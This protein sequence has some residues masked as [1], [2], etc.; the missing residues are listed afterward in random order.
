MCGI[1]G[2]LS[3][4]HQIDRSTLERMNNVARHRGPDDE[5]YALISRKSVNLFCGRDSRS[6]NFPLFPEGVFEDTFL[7]FGH[8]RL[9]ILDLSMKGHQPMCS[10]DG[11]ICV[12]FN[13]EIYNYIELRREL[14]SKGHTF[15]S[16]SD[17][18]VLIASYRE[19]G[20]D[21]VAHFNGMWGFAIWDEAR[22]KLFCSRDRLGAK[23]FYYYKD[24]ENFLFSSEMKQICQN[25]IVPRRMNESLLA[26]EI[27]WRIS[28][29]SDECWLQ[30][31]KVLQ[32]GDNLVL[33]IADTDGDRIEDCRVYSYWDIDASGDKDTAAVERALDLHREAV[34]IR[35]RSDVPI[36]IM[37]SGGLDSS[38][39]VADISEYYREIG[40]NPE[41]IK[42][43]TSCYRDFREGDECEY[44][45]AVNKHCGTT[46]RF[47]YPDEND[48][49]SA[50]E[51]FIWHQEGMA[52]IGALGA[53]LLLR[54]VATSGVKVLINGQ[55]SDETMFGYE[56]Y[57]VWY[58]K[59]ILEKQGVGAFFRAWNLAVEHSRLSH[60]T[61][62]AYMAYFLSYSLRKKRNEFRTREYVSP[63][64]L[65][66][67]KNN[68]EIRRFV[69]FENMKDMQYN[70]IRKTQ[71]AQ[72]LH[73][74]DRIYMAFSIESRVPFI[75]YR[76]IEEAVKIP[77]HMKIIDGYTKYPIRKYVEGR[78]PDYVVWRKNKMC[79]PSPWKLWVDRLDKKRIS[80]MFHEARS[81][82]YFNVPAIYK[83]WTMDPYNYVVRQFFNVEIF[84]Q[85]FDVA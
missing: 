63:Q 53:F 19:W 7:A 23:P 28:D 82:R 35:T 60:L 31:I 13:G 26:T 65:Q 36:G 83:L 79:W 27:F 1:C 39:L 71:L 10:E 18:E 85:L 68:D 49:L 44:A 25:P 16:N 20:E 51:K 29:F 84:M 76:Y 69:A 77:E 59:E 21:C 64:I 46:E 17:T 32:G 12:T 70:E 33:T 42:T 22:R 80:K 74:D 78:L 66:C 11:K 75:D 14:A 41:E 56:R 57:Y 61:L 38:T 47:L 3:T 40:R 5:G 67:F 48:T 58:L 45:H 30:D 6:S 52:D 81:E 8:R 9:S 54:E 62:S 37:L 4:N 24:S 15:Y 50:W 72:I 2:W 73:M 55:G 34:R 43:F